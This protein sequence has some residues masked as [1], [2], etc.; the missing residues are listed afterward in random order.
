MTYLRHAAPILIALFGVLAFACSPRNTERSVDRDEVLDEYEDPGLDASE[1]APPAGGFT[2]AGVLSAVNE[3]GGLT[4][5]PKGL[6][7]SVLNDYIT[8]LAGVPSAR[9][10]V[11]DLELIRGELTSGI[12]DR[13]DVGAALQRLAS[14]T[15]QIAGDGSPYN[16][17]ANALALSGEQLGGDPDDLPEDGD[18][19]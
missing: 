6:A 12:I 11:P 5:L 14:G 9:G 16:A 19:R 8:R 13:G 4:K 2:P 15:R 18:G 17:L 3:A 7:V 10:L 1:Y